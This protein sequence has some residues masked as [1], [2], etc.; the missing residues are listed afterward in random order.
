M[1]KRLTLDEVFTPASSLLPEENK[2]S[3]LERI[4]SESVIKQTSNQ[5]S[6]HASKQ[7]VG[8]ARKEITIRL[9]EE[10]WDRLEYAAMNRKLNRIEPFSKQDI[11]EV[12]L[13]EW[14]N[15]N[16]V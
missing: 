15:R 11:M 6:K 5:V 16:D 10:Y 2:P 8:V 1:S 4:N 12:A 13:M 3:N 9:R 14:L 7:A